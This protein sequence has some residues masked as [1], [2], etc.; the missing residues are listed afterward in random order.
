[1]RTRRKEPDL[2]PPN[3]E[4]RIAYLAGESVE[5]L[6]AEERAALDD[7]RSLLQAPATWT[8]PDPGL[9]DRV[10]VA[11]A[12]EAH[13]GPAS[14]GRASARRRSR[15]RLPLRLGRP[16]F[17]LAGA[18]AAALAAIV[19]GLAVGGR[20]PTPLRFALVLSG[21]E[22][23]PGAHGSATLTKTT[24]GWRIQLSATGL[25]RLANGRYYEAWLKSPAG[26]LVPVGTFNQPIH[27]TLWAGVPPTS[28]PTLTVTEQLA[29]GDPRS[30]GQRVLVGT[31]TT[32]R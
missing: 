23:A 17:A 7:L 15:L 4:D 1:L 11:I 22:L 29:N 21:T 30:S 20:G 14:A 28:F 24:S 12:A 13:A 32:R 3:D 25:P 18:A 9:E 10:V 26:I 31:I 5:T 8:E 6:S 2:P 27:I 19:I 16:A